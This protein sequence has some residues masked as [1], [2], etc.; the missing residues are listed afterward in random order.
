MS[1]WDCVGGLL[2]V[3]EAGGRVGRYPGPGG[4]K[5]GG[6]VIAAAPGVAVVILT[7]YDDAET[8]GR[9][10]AAGA[11]GF[12]AKHD[13]EGRLVDQIRLAANPPQRPPR[14]EG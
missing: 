14:T 12:V 2:M 5:A 9:A 6:A 4:L 10:A 7:L 11:A 8:R 13:S 1:P 3:R